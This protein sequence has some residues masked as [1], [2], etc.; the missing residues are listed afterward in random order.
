MGVL[1]FI[2][3]GRELPL[4]SYGYK[5]TLKELEKVGNKGMMLE[6]VSGK[7]VKIFETLED[8][9]GIDILELNGH[10]AIRDRFQQRYIY[11][12]QCSPNRKGYRELFS[13]INNN[14]LKNEFIEIYSCLKG[15]EMREK[16]DSLDVHIDLG[17]LEY[18][19]PLGRIPLKGKEYIRQLSEIFWLRENQYVMIRK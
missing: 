19:G 15:H 18:N 4:G 13:Y 12:L 10:E 2:A 17:K 11:E 1:H 16:D 8:T 5:W 7:Y 9:Y 6:A 14:L 3:A